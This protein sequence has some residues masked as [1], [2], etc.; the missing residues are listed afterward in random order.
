MKF[1]V[2]GRHEIER[3]IVVKGR[4]ALIS[5]S[6]PT[7]RPPK[8]R[9]QP[10]LRATLQ[11]RFH[12]AEP[13]ASLTLPAGITLVSEQDALTVAGFVA[14]HRA[15]VDYIVVHCEQGMSRS[16]AVASAIAWALGENHGRFFDEY[17]PNQ[18]VFEM[19]KRAFERERNPAGDQK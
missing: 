6:D 4:Y 7:K 14:E 2:A 18:Y 16:P 3:G 13:T 9:R 1:L 11:L 10:G 8:V 17:Q 15:S 5:I 12:D 19:I